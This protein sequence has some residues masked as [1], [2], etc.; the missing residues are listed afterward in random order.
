MT[1][2]NNVIQ[3][4]APRELAELTY[5][6]CRDA[7]KRPRRIIEFSLNVERFRRLLTTDAD[8]REDQLA[9]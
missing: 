5:S 9:G 3:G 7:H 8:E 4:P 6:S 1:F 2:V